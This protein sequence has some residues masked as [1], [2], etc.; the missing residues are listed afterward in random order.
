MLLIVPPYHQRYSVHVFYSGFQILIHLPTEQFP[1]FPQ[2][3]L[4]S[5][6]R[7]DCIS[8]SF[9]HITYSLHGRA[10]TCICGWH[11]QW[12]PSLLSLCSGFFFY[13]CIGSLFLIECWGPEDHERPVLRFFFFF[14]LVN[15]C[16]SLLLKKTAFL[17]CY[18]YVYNLVTDLLPVNLISGKMFQNC[19]P[20]VSV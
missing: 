15:Q 7:D 12:F 20:V 2:C 16:T 14:R 8:G 4:I 13:H 19:P 18:P 9:S 17:R 3:I 10:L 1:T 11:T 5:F 6:V